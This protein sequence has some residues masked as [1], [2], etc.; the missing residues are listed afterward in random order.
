MSRSSIFWAVVFLAYGSIFSRPASAQ[1][2]Y[3]PQTPTIS[4]WMNLWQNRT[5]TLGNYQCVVVP[6][7]QLNQTLQMQNA[8][9]TSQAAGMQMMGDEVSQPGQI[10]S[11]MMPTG[12]R[13]SATYMNYLHYYPAMGRPGSGMAGTRGNTGTDLSDL[14]HTCRVGGSKHRVEE[15]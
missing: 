15:K 5:G 13:T 4:P 9:L 3:T 6:Q 8:A 10:Q 2:G 1:Y 14:A 11:S 12:G 7:M